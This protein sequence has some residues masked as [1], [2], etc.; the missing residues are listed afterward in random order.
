M[1]FIA[2][3]HLVME[4][5]SLPTLIGGDFNLVLNES[6]K[7][8][9]NINHQL[10]FLFNDWMNKWALI[11]LPISNRSFTWAN[12]QEN[13]ILATL[14]HIFVS[15]DWDSKFPLSLVRAIPNSGGDHTPLIIE[16]GVSPPPV[17]KLFRFEKWWLS[18]PEF[19]P[20][21]IKSWTAPIPSSLKTAIDIWQFKVRRLRTNLKGWNSNVE[22]S[23]KKP[24]KDLLQEYDILDVF[25]EQN[26][27]DQA[28]RARMLQIKNDLDLI[29]KTEETKA[30][31][32]SREKDILEGDRNTAY[33]HAVANQRRR[34]KQLAMLDGSSGPVTTTPEMQVVACDYYKE[35]FGFED[36]PNMHLGSDFWDPDDL[37]TEL[38][39]EALEKP[40]SEEE[41][42]EAILG[43]YA[44]GA[45]GPDG[46][47]FLFY[48][49]F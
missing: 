28:D 7:S 2:E 24:K 29:W 22:A 15:T 18:E 40:F 10:T 48:Q 27:L 3:L 41:V 23:L 26:R 38:E 14:D 19:I 17:Q 37:V 44:N 25:S 4:N 39:N 9:G 45:P 6:E 11:D 43:S 33:F 30:F 12:N 20:F 8:N 13:L 21:V 46:L 34:K 31:Q 42:K 47:S 1:D 16:F 5:C 49:T 36:R 35:L 32:R